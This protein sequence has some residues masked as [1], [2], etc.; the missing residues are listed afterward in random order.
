MSESSDSNS[1]N[2]DHDPVKLL[3]HK[4]R[5]ISG[6][7][8]GRIKDAVEEISKKDQVSDLDK[9]ITSHLLLD[10][11]DQKKDAERNAV[12]NVVKRLSRKQDEE[13]S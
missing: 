6:I 1:D 10:K 12:L 9:K 13:Q 2:N 8:K 4:N 5:I 11:N 3:N 7:L